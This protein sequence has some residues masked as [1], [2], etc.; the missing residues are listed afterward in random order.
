MSDLRHQPQTVET[1]TR[2]L[3]DGYERI[4]QALARGEDVTAWEE[5]WIELLHQYEQ[6]S[7]ERDPVGKEADF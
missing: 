5:F 1:L 3:N 4:E 6:L 7:D 2:R